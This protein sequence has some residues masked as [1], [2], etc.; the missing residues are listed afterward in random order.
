MISDSIPESASRNYDDILS[1]ARSNL[2]PLKRKTL[3]CSD[4]RIGKILEGVRFGYD[5]C[6]P[7]AESAADP[8]SAPNFLRNLLMQESGDDDVSNRHHKLAVIATHAV[9]LECGFVPFDKES[10]AVVSGFRSPLVWPTRRLFYTLPEKNTAHGKS[11]QNAVLEFRISGEYSVTVNGRLDME[12]EKVG[13][14][15]VQFKEDQLATFMNNVLVTDNNNTNGEEVNGGAVYRFWK[16]VKDNLVLPLLTELRQVSCYC[17]KLPVDLKVEI[18]KWL[19]AVDLA[20]ATCF[21][22]ELSSIASRDDYLWKIKFVQEFG[23]LDKDT[24]VS[25][26]TAFRRKNIN[27]KKVSSKKIKKNNDNN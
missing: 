21:C 26:K 6:A 23:D 27:T 24:S 16:R 20:K 11:I 22:Y 4:S 5:D 2:V 14:H 17:Q 9:M 3:D 1:D 12:T 13:N 25:W 7:A 18:L 19:S 8:F 15:S 10:N